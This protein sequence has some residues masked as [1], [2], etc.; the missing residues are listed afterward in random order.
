MMTTIRKA[1]SKHPA[2]LLSIASYLIAWATPGPQAWATDEPA[3]SKALA[4]FVNGLAERPSREATALLA[5]LAEL[6]L[7]DDVLRARCREE[8]ARRHDRL[9]KWIVGLPDLE[10][11]RVLRRTTVL[12]DG[13]E[14]VLGLRLADSTELTL[15]VFLDH[16]DLSSVTDFAVLAEP[17]DRA[18]N[19]AAERGDKATSF[20]EMDPANARSWIERGL[21]VQDYLPRPERWR[22]T[23]PLMR[24]LVTRLPDGGTEYER[25]EHDE[26]TTSK[27]IDGFFTS[28]AGAPFASTEYQELLGELCETGYGNPWRWSA[29]RL[30]GI[31]QH[32]FHDRYLPL[33]IAVDVPALLRAFVPF[34]HADCGVRQ[35]LTDEAIATIDA[36]SLRY[37]REL[38]SEAA[39]R[40][41]D[42][43][44]PPR[45]LTHRNQAS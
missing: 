3:K 1:L 11:H 39:E 2:H 30:S 21:R 19:R 36:M 42:A 35:D 25:P 31:L 20:L 13:D 38:L 45:W 5:V 14:L 37:R 6:L 43:V 32:P 29:S 16:N 24:W 28:P 33:E 22:E 18:L 15:S 23:T 17:L 4:S 7:D 12:G 8:S 27:L 41:E 9:P 44:E 40:Y 34:A 26:D 10:V